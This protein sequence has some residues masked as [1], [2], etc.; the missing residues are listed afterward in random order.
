LPTPSNVGITAYG[1]SWKYL[2]KKMMRCIFE[3]FLC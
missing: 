2:S 3:K 1:F